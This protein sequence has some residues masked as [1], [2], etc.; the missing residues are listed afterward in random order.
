MCSRTQKIDAVNFAEDR[1]A[2]G[3]DSLPIT[4]IH[5]DDSN[6]AERPFLA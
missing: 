1:V 2:C 3:F 6:V 4:D 5:L